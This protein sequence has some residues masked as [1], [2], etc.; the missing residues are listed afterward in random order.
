MPL[1]FVGI[2][3]KSEDGDS[4]TVWI[5]TDKQELLLQGWTATPE[6]EARVY[7]EAG[8]AAGHAPGV[9]SHETIVRIPA[10]MVSAIRKACDDLERPAV[11]Q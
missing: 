11:D 9:P 10:R 2:D 4:P 8:T 1:I 7:Q 5:D 6:E 3:P